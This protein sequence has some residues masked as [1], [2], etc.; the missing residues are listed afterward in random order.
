V[1]AATSPAVRP[2]RWWPEGSVSVW[3][4]RPPRR[5]GLPPRRGRRSDLT[6]RQDA[7]HLPGVRFPPAKSA[8]AIVATVCL[9]VAIRSQSFSLSQRFDP[10]RALWLCF[11]P[12]PP[13]GF[14]PSKPFPPSQPHSLSGAVALLPL[15][16]RRPPRWLPPPAFWSTRPTRPAQHEP[17]MNLRYLPRRQSINPTTANRSRQYE[18]SGPSHCTKRCTQA[19]PKTMLGSD[20]SFVAAL[21]AGASLTSEPCSDGASVPQLL[22]LNVSWSRCSLDLSLSAVCQLDRWA[23]ALPSCASPADNAG[24]GAPRSHSIEPGTNSEELAQPP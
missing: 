19:R 2:R 14:R 10:A 11:A 12:H 8:R 17:R 18:V 6:G 16:G 7:R 3:P 1:T 9:T 13:M 24:G 22:L 20:R 5:R 4:T 21:P 15:A 23:E